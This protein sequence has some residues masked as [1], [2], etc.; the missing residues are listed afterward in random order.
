MCSNA[1]PVQHPD[2]LVFNS[3]MMAAASLARAL[4]LSFT[5]LARPPGGSMLI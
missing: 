1:M 4:G 5:K 2:K 3:A